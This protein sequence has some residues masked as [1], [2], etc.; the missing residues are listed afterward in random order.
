MGEAVLSLRDHPGLEHVLAVLEL[1]RKAV[2]VELDG[3]RAPKTQAEYAQAHGRRDGLDAARRA[4][5]AIVATYQ[6]RLHEQQ[7]KHEAGG[8]SLA[9]GG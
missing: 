2:D 6:T 9:E 7:R 5:D 3:A 4:I 8:E 1:E